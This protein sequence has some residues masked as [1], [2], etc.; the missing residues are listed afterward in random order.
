M[1]LVPL[2]VNR[3]TLV[4]LHQ[5]AR[6]RVA[7]AVHLVRFEPGQGA[8]P[9]ERLGDAAESAG[10]RDDPRQ[11]WRREAIGPGLRVDVAQALEDRIV[12]RP[13]GVM[14]DRVE[15]RGQRRERVRDDGVAPVEEPVAVGP[16][17]D[18]A[19]V[20]VVV[21]DG[22]G[23]PG[24]LELRDG[25]IDRGEAAAEAPA[26]GVGGG[27]LVVRDPGPGH[28]ILEEPCQL[29]GE[30]ARP[31]VRDARGQHLVACRLALDRALE[32]RVLG[33]DPLPRGDVVVA[34]AVGT[35]RPQR[36]PAVIEQQPRP[37]GMD[38]S[39]SRTSSTPWRRN[40]SSNGPSCAAPGP[41]ALNQ[42]VVP[43]VG[44]RIAVDHG[45]TCG[46]SIGPVTR[47]PSPSSVAAI[48]ASAP[49]RHSGSSQVLA[50]VGI[51][52]SCPRRRA[53]RTRRA[54][55]PARAAT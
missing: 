49:A 23:D 24:R 1:L 6:D 22:G 36:G 48:Q 32:C 47:R 53:S 9:G 2:P 14:G 51:S 50:P 37:L 33:E 17:Q 18:V 19:A 3:D 42:T 13:P 11:F 12:E 30:P 44:T 45:R 46:C 5:P 54:R 34:R 21:L 35:C 55:C 7:V 39:G 15:G 38:A 8:F 26:S 40:T 16:D 25:G 52:G 27:T 29:P 41:D 4:E 20:Q 28:V 31:P 10:E 43:S